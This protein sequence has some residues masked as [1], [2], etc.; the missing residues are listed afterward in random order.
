MYD[1]NRSACDTAEANFRARVECADLSRQSEI[2]FPDVDIVVGSP[3]CQGFSNEGKKNPDDLRNGLVWAFLDIVERVQ[4]RVWVFENVPGFQRSYG[5]RWFKALAARVDASGY[6]WAHYILDAADFGVPQH[7][8]RFLILAA[9]DFRPTAPT[10]THAEVASLLGEKPYIALWDAISDLPQAVL[11]DRIGTFDYP[12]RPLSPFQE[13]ARHGSHRI[14]NHTAQNH[15]ERV[16]EKIRAV[17]MGGD[18][19]SFI[20]GYKENAVH[21]MGGY[22]RAPKTRPSWTAYWTRGMT[23]IH[24]EQHRFLSPRECARI[25]SFPDRLK[26][27]GTTIENYTQVCNAVPPLLAEAI[28]TSL[29]HQIATRSAV[30]HRKA[31]AA[32]NPKF[33][34][35]GG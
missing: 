8:R 25:Q 9:K 6:K 30:H 26:F 24:P 15:S 3:P 1:H 32:A 31:R 20:D 2:E 23:S 14:Y 29:A 21:Y 5:G 13:W 19:L 27:L 28:A 35:D 7:R 16:L 4:P 22:R 10:A 34:A 12:G 17:P 33:G 11:G 18:M